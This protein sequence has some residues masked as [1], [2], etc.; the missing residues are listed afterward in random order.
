MTVLHATKVAVP[1]PAM[2]AGSSALSSVAVSSGSNHYHHHQSRNRMPSTVTT[3]NKPKKKK[4]LKMLQITHLLGKTSSSKSM[5]TSSSSSSSSSSPGCSTENNNDYIVVE[6]EQYHRDH[7]HH[8]GNSRCNEITATS[9]PPFR[10][11][12]PSSLKTTNT[13]RT[14]NGP[15]AAVSKYPSTRYTKASSTCCTSSIPD[16]RVRGEGFRWFRTGLRQH[17]KS[18]ATASSSSQPILRRHRVFPSLKRKILPHDRFRSNS[19]IRNALSHSILQ[20][21]NTT[22]SSSSSGSTRGVDDDHMTEYPGPIMNEYGDCHTDE[23]LNIVVSADD[24]TTTAQ[25]MMDISDQYYCIG[26]YYQYELCQSQLALQYYYN[27][28]YTAIQCYRNIVVVMSSTS[29]SPKDNKTKIVCK[30]DDAPTTLKVEIEVITSTTTDTSSKNVNMND[31]N[32][33]AAATTTTT[34][35]TSSSSSSSQLLLLL[36]EIQGHI[37][38]TKECI[39]RIHFE[40]GN[41]DEALE[42]L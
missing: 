27:A 1:V 16:Q 39:G 19:N 5:S 2:T 42:M 37:Q 40:L 20:T 13:L 15:N 28:Y 17:S 6:F 10:I 11:I 29:S 35:I 31:A 9:I 36:E 38:L 8:Q 4:A 7:H 14:S 12:P 23:D 34:T 18:V 26:K 21:L 30:D 22:S 41:I 32:V 33:A 3:A 24:A 25:M